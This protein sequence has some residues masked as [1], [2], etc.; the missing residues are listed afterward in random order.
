[1]SALLNGT[2]PKE[3]WPVLVHELTHHWCFTT[4]VGEALTILYLK[5]ILSM[6]GQSPANPYELG[7]DLITYDMMRGL[8]FPLI[9]GMALFAEF[10]VIPNR[11]SDSYSTPLHWAA[12]LYAR[13]DRPEDID[14]SVLRFLLDQR[15]SRQVIR[16]KAALLCQPLRNA[17][18]DYLAAYLMVKNI[19]ITLAQK[20]KR[21]WETDT[22]LR[23]LHWYFFGDMSTVARLLE[24]D[25]GKRDRFAA[26]SDAF[27]ANL[28]HLV[29][30]TNEELVDIVDAIAAGVEQTSGD[31][32]PEYQLWSETSTWADEWKARP[33]F[34][35]DRLSW[36]RGI[37][38]LAK[39][40]GDLHD[41][42]EDDPNAVAKLSFMWLITQR[43]SFCVLHEPIR[44]TVT[45]YGRL[46]GVYRGYNMM[47]ASPIDGF[48]LPPG[49]YDG[50]L[51]AYLLPGL[52]ARFVALGVDGHVGGLTVLGKVPARFEQQLAGYRMDSDETLAELAELRQRAWD[53]ANQDSVVPIISNAINEN[54][55]TWHNEVARR[56]LPHL[57]RSNENAILGQLDQAGF[58]A[59]THS[60]SRVRALAAI[61]LLASF[62]IARDSMA[63]LFDT[64]RQSHD[65]DEDFEESVSSIRRRGS[66]LLND[67][68]LY[69]ADQIRSAV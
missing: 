26:V 57:A 61:S 45:A 49:E 53:R 66:D 30:I 34:G 32:G 2:M 46:Q 36:D 42:A 7:N 63:K 54:I 52:H 19:W 5:P 44:V 50:T 55:T 20:D 60:T 3:I 12:T 6:T 28:S 23:F 14:D 25:D 16:R 48:A 10:D 13:P 29:D 15:L 65:S 64:N 67:Q 31:L 59:V 33:R 24:P 21:L 4:A 41:Y 58:I 56:A 69:G 51:S 22:F 8:L 9:E 39:E 62:P 43:D 68:L 35:N 17:G 27:N 40:L 11:Q 38:L 18:E 47:S 1:M 37:D